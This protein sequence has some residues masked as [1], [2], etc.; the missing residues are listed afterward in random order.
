MLEFDPAHWLPTLGR[1]AC[2]GHQF[3]SFHWNRCR[4]RWSTG[5]TSSAA[6]TMKASPA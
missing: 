5:V 3:F 4:S 2:L 6:V 1:L